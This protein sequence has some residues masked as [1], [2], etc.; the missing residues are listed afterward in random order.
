MEKLWRS[1]GWDNPCTAN[2]QGITCTLTSLR[3][4]YVD[5]LNFS[6]RLEKGPQHVLRDVSWN[7]Q[8]A[9]A[10]RWLAEYLA[11]MAASIS[12]TNAGL[13]T[14]GAHSE[15][16]ASSNQHCPAECVYTNESQHFYEL[17]HILPQL[18]ICIKSRLLQEQLSDIGYPQSQSAYSTKHLLA[19]LI[20]RT[21]DGQ[22]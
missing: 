16:L 15:Q 14:A 7:L 8:T 18:L 11:M 10:L 19:S 17:L 2:E 13:L 1:C 12:H 4:K 22:P 21:L 6:I 20:P 3:P 5:V 9:L